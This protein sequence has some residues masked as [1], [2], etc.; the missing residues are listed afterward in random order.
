MEERGTDSRLPSTAFRSAMPVVVDGF[1]M[2]EE[3]EK[4]AT[5]VEPAKTD[6]PMPGLQ[7]ILNKEVHLLRRIFWACIVLA[8]IISSTIQVKMQLR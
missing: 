4:N 3:N 8:V 2:Q 5:K 1:P 7:F 6:I